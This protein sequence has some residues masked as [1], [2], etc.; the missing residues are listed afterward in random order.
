MFSFRPL[1]SRVAYKARTATKALRT[2][3]TVTPT[4]TPSDLAVEE[5][6]APEAPLPEAVGDPV[7]TPSAPVEVP[8]GLAAPEVWEPVEPDPVAVASDPD[9]V[10]APVGAGVDVTRTA[11]ERRQLRWQVS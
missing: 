3:A 9:L 5:A 8:A 11:D 1:L 7:A 6:E 2:P 10:A 4:R